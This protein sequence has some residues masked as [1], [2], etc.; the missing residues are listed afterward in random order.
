MKY[1]RI[2]LRIPSD[3]PIVIGLFGRQHPTSHLVVSH[4]ATKLKEHIYFM[5]ADALLPGK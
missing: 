3:W 2:A 1:Q 5:C 4:P